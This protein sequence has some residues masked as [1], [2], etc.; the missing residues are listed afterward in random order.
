VSAVDQGVKHLHGRELGAAAGRSGHYAHDLHLLALTFVNYLPT[1]KWEIRNMQVAYPSLTIPSAVSRNRRHRDE[2]RSARLLLDG[3]PEADT[4]WSDAEPDRLLGT[5]AMRRAVRARPVPARP[6]R[7][8]QQLLYRQGR[9]DY[10]PAV[11]A[12]LLAARHSLLAERALEQPPRFLVRVDEFPHALA[13]DKS[14]PYGTEGYRRFHAI[15][16]A[17]GVPYLV[18]VPTRVSHAPLDPQGQR[19]RAL[20][21]SERELLCGLA[22]DP[23]SG[24][25]FA[26]H[27]RDHRTRFQAPRRRSEL[28]GLD[29]D[30]TA[31]LLD[32][33]LAELAALGIAT[34]VFVPPF[35]R[36]DARQYDQLASRFAVVCGGPESIGLLG[37]QSSPMWRGDAVYLPSYR[38][39]Y[40][41]AGDVLPAAR[42]LIDDAPGLWL[43]IVLHWGWEADDGW[44]ELER[45]AALI[46]PYAADWKDFLA[47]V[48]RS[49]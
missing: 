49:A 22:D 9:L 25:T 21:E 10:E 20:E 4:P 34:E 19:W 32:G 43:P 46:A 42:R 18:A 23:G 27:G 17:A 36:F 31:A 3:G 28:C 47:A 16:A 15:M 24:V 11:V 38:P 13:W 5:R 40:G 33:A 1:L 39:L 12:P 6:W 44:Q 35:N 14:G 29:A 45:L 48:R 2:A 30:A 41:H 26:L 37:F 7:F 8:A